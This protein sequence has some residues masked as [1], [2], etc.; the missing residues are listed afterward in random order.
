MT[1]EKKK[2]RVKD[3]VYL[4]K[5]VTNVEDPPKTDKPASPAQPGS[6]T[7]QDPPK[8]KLEDGLWVTDFSESM[9]N[10]PKTDVPDYV[11]AQPIGNTEPGTAPAPI[12]TTPGSMVNPPDAGF[13]QWKQKVSGVNPN[14]VQ[15][16]DYNL[17]GA[18]EGGLEPEL[19]DDGTYHLGSRNPKTGELLKSKTHPTYDKMIEG[20]RQAGYEVYEQDGKMYSR[21]SA[22][23]NPATELVSERP[24]YAATLE[25]V[26]QNGGNAILALLGQQA[27]KLDEER[28]KRLQRMAAIKGIGNSLGLI[29]QAVYGRKGANIPVQEDNLIPAA[30]NEYMENIRNFENKKLQHDAQ[31]TAAKMREI[32]MAT[33]M[34]ERDKDRYYGDQM[35]TKQFGQQ[36]DMNQTQFG[37][38]KELTQ[39]EFD[40]REKLAKMTFDN[41][42]TMFDKQTAADL[43]KMAKQYGYQA[44]LQASTFKHQSKMQQD[45]ID[46]GKFDPKGT[47]AIQR[48]KQNGPF[49]YYS[50]AYGNSNTGSVMLNPG[51]DG[52]VEYVL[53]E[54]MKNPRRY[55]KHKDVLNKIAD[56]TMTETEARTIMNLYADD[57]ITVV[58][59]VASIKVEPG[60][61]EDSATGGA[62]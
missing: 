4:D 29:S 20:E 16:N 61:E 49:M 26:R 46:A 53:S 58:D 43:V 24:D 51:Q 17:R 57:Y 12:P 42:L 59:G 6:E 19:A 45:A 8:R 31:V 40:N 32:E 48:N 13:E 9:K 55:R 27:P 44:A 36:K 2:R 41:Q 38:Q 15:G 60:T 34:H 30:Y 33:N 28:Q 7:A 39:A 5:P 35:N 3:L 52:I 21:P 54:V 18:Y 50:K 10:S 14:L 23:P 25:Q 37:Q 1:T 22:Q 47:G 62:Y 11:P 56:G